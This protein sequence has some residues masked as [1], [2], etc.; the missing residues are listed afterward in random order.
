MNQQN[1]VQVGLQI[2]LFF[3][4]GRECLPCNGRSCSLFFAEGSNTNLEIGFHG[5]LLDAWY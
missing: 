5:S 3:E 2:E 4:Y 1:F